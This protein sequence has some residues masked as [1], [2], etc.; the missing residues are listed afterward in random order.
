MSVKQ[1]IV[2]SALVL[3]SSPRTRYLLLLSVVMP[4]VVFAVGVYCVAGI[5]LGEPYGP[6]AVAAREAVFHLSLGAAL[7][8][9]VGTLSLAGK[10]FGRARRRIFG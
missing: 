4:V 10:E 6:L 5:T 8:V 1:I 7:S 9:W 3:E 2:D